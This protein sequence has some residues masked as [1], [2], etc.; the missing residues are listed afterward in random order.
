MLE[1]LAL[2][3]HVYLFHWFLFH[4]LQNLAQKGH[5]KYLISECVHGLNFQKRTTLP[6]SSVVSIAWGCAAPPPHS[7]LGLVRKPTTAFCAQKTK[8][9]KN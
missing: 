9:S 1:F 8:P 4:L 3:K 2:R 5:K 6:G 7:P